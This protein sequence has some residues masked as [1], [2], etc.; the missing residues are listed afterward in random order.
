VQTIVLSVEEEMVKRKIAATIAI[1]SKVE[2]PR[3]YLIW[4][5]F[6]FSISFDTYHAAA[7]T[8]WFSTY[9]ASISPSSGTPASPLSSLPRYRLRACLLL[10]FIASVWCVE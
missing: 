10:K 5:I 4:E 7:R 3:I 9:D 8:T 2:G 1:D 6:Y